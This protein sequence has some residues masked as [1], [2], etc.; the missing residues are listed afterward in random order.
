MS[1]ENKKKIKFCVYCGSDVKENEIYCPKC[2]KLVIKIEAGK[3][4]P[5]PQITQKLEISRKC[6]GCGSVITSTVLDQCPICN[7]E[8]EKIAEFK[9]AAIQKKP[10]LIFTSKKLEPEQK[11]ILKKDT[12][13][14]K[15]GVN[16]FGAIIETDKI[17]QR[18]NMVLKKGLNSDYFFSIN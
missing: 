13:N 18:E 1:K 11:F 9:R 8:L 10:G 17:E 16:V 7:T 14:L 2:G 15:E 4:V 6:P 12:W 5:K 3:E